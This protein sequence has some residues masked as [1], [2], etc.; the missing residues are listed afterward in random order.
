MLAR[1][2]ATKR[3]DDILGAAGHAHSSMKRSLGPVSVTLLGIGAIIGT[4]IYAT[5]GTATANATILN[6]DA[7]VGIAATSAV[8]S[9]ASSRMRATV[10]PRQLT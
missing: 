6:D 4:G 5:I 2:F 1:L 3:L 7:L 8:R 9:R 10:R